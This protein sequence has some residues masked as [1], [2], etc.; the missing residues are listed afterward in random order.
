MRKLAVALVGLGLVASMAMPAGARGGQTRVT[1]DCFHTKA[2]PD[3]ILFTC[4]DGNYY[5]R[6]LNWRH[7]GHLHARG[8]GVFHFND[9]KPD[10]ARGTFH[11]RRGRIR[12]HRVRYCKNVGHYVFTRAKIVY[13]HPY[14]HDRRDRERLFC[15]IR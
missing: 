5:A 15:P 8:H 1:W 9:C 4:A 6:R 11:A 10:C 2:R 3:S 12:L 14:H 13:R 7:W